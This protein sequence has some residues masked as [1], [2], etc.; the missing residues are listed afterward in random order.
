M[1]GNPA[2]PISVVPAVGHPAQDRESLH[3]LLRPLEERGTIRATGIVQADP[4]L[5]L[6]IVT[7][8]EIG[9]LP[10]SKLLIKLVTDT[11]EIILHLLA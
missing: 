5:C 10:A 9:S 8:D 1:G 11:R 3:L 7:D 6:K 4:T 2:L